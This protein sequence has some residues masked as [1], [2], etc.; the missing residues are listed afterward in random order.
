M[1]ADGF[2]GFLGD[3]VLVLAAGVSRESDGLDGLACCEFAACSRLVCGFAAHLMACE[4]VG[5]ENR[6]M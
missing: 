3:T 4:C 6:L 5:Y 2:D 1:A